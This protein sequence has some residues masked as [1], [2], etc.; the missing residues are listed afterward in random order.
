MAEPRAASDV[1]PLSLW[2][3]VA[4]TREPPTYRLGRLVAVVLRERLAAS[5]LS[6]NALTFAWTVCL[7]GASGALAVGEYQYGLL[8]A[9][10]ILLS[11]VLD[12]LDGEA[13]RAR[14]RTSKIGS[15][16]EQMAH[17][18]TNGCLLLG[19]VVGLSHGGNRMWV[20]VVL[21]AA[22]IGDYTFH[23]L[24]QQLHLAADRNLDYGALHIVTRWLYALMPINTNL[25]IVGAVA[26]EL[27]GALVVWAALSNV[28][29]LVIF[30][31]YYRVESRELR[32]QIAQAEAEASATAP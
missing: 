29:W 3:E 1:R 32:R 6:P 19:T 10:L 5:R 22:L 18:V 14:G 28:A 17:W 12:C 2:S 20:W 26:S 4:A 7:I 25:L 11:Y 9:A 15:Q 31:I 30:G 27:L 23:F 21:A 8:A 16:L 24:Y 13:A